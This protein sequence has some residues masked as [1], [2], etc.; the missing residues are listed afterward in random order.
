[1]PGVIDSQPLQL[2]FQGWAT[3]RLGVITGIRRDNAH[4]ALCP[5]S[6]D[7]AVS[8][9]RVSR[10]TRG[11]G[12]RVC[13]R[14]CIVVAAEHARSESWGKMYEIKNDSLIDQATVS[15]PSVKTDNKDNQNEHAVRVAVV[16]QR[17]KEEIATGHAP[18]LMVDSDA[19]H[20]VVRRK[21][22]TAWQARAASTFAKTSPSTVRAKGPAKDQTKQLDALA[23]CISRL[24]AVKVV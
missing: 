8:A 19:P 9:T 12:W 24:S 11:C 18:D 6:C 20:V 2:R 22:K 7:E 23:N 17:F 15:Q 21:A 3:Q 10:E 1:M 13:V 16:W 5:L 14:G 4:K